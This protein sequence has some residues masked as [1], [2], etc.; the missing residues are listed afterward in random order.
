MIMNAS[1]NG[2]TC[3]PTSGPFCEDLKWHVS[4]ENVFPVHGGQGSYVTR[5]S[6]CDKP[7]GK[8]YVM[9]GKSPICKPSRRGENALYF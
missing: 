1:R 8:P 9:N 6:F 3:N 5:S 7:D 4:W 2:T